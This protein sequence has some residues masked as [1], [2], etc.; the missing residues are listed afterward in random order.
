MEITD[1][2]QVLM[3]NTEQ[4]V[5]LDIFR[6]NGQVLMQ[7]YKQKDVTKWELGVELVDKNG[8]VIEITFHPNKS[9]NK[10]NIKR[11]LESELYKKFNKY[12]S[13]EQNSY[14][15]GIP[16]NWNIKNI[17]DI[18][19]KILSDIFNMK[20]KNIHFTLNAY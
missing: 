18:I 2:I 5:Q 1:S 15:I 17:E 19:L 8:F 11:F 13:I 20:I 12:D 7:V 6:E 16:S 3:N 14:F 4:N 9:K 10:E